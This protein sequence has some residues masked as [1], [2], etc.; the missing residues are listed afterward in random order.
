MAETQDATVGYMGEF[1]LHNGSVLYELVEVQSFKIPEPGGREQVET[2]HLKSPGWRRT[3]V[4]TFYEDSDFEVTLN[5][6]LRSDTDALLS[7]ALAADDV[8]AFKATIPENGVETSQIEGTC[9]VIGYDRGTVEKDSV[10][11]STVTL[12]V[13][14]IDAVEAAA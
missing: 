1:H 3:H 11:T 12:R 14:T 13:V 9:R 4:S 10:I 8:R 7:A 2:T 6:R 5:T